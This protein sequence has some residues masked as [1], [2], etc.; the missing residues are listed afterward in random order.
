MN[1]HDKTYANSKEEAEVRRI[2]A[3][4]AKFEQEK[5]KLELETKELER[6]Q[7]LPWYRKRQFFQALGGITAIFL[8]WSF[9]DK[10]IK[11]IY[12][13]KTIQLSR[14]IE[15]K[16]DSLNQL[17]KVFQVRIATLQAEEAV[18]IERYIT[19]LKTIRDERDSLKL[20]MEKL[21]QQ[22]EKLINEG[23]LARTERDSYS[24]KFRETQQELNKEK[25]KT[26]A[27]SARISEGEKRYENVSQSNQ[28]SRFSI[29][30]GALSQLPS[31]GIQ[32]MFNTFIRNNLTVEDIQELLQ[33]KGYF[34]GEINGMYD[35]RTVEAV[36]K[37]QK[38]VGAQQDGILGP[39]TISKLLEK[40]K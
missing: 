30:I 16:Q 8:V 6:Y 31:S 12:E 13:L 26:R 28:R 22:Y 35:K 40:R 17:N 18:H 37:F 34:H 38:A 21:L 25:E 33:D 10:F 1:N 2:N 29:E 20:K 27:L 15:A 19:E 32:E 24:R 5:I 9:F 3:E 7:K 4:I 39:V 11:P 36:K 14:E 23:S